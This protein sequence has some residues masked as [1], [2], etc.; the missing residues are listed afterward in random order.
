[1]PGENNGDRKQPAA[2]SSIIEPFPDNVILGKGSSQAWRPGNTRFHNILNCLADQ[3]HKAT[4]NVEKAAIIHAVYCDITTH[5]RFLIKQPHAESY[6]E[7]DKRD[8]KKRTGQAMRYRRRQH[9]DDTGEG[10]RET[11]APLAEAIAPPIASDV[12]QL[13]F[14]APPALPPVPAFSF[15]ASIPIP[16]AAPLPLPPISSST[17]A[18]GTESL[19]TMG[20]QIH[21]AAA[22]SETETTKSSSWTKT[23]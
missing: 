16:V 15:A 5:G 7:I 6:V 3:Y 14:A 4:S 10:E 13:A 22:P 2:P 23:S 19:P 11:Q 17:T 21:E 12:A 1:M 8:A 9:T 18:G 20:G